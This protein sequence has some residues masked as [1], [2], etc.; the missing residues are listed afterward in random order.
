VDHVPVLLEEALHLLAVRP[1]GVYLDGTLGAG[2]HAAEI[3]RRS[4]PEGRVI[5]F[6]KDARA[7]E[8]ARE[9]LAP[10][11]GRVSFVHA[12]F[13]EAKAVL[14]EEKL[15]GVLL[16]LGVSSLQLDAPERGFSFRA[17]GPLDMRMDESRGPTAADLVNRLP[18]SALADLVYRYGEEPASRR[19]ARALVAAR[20]KKPFSTTGELAA[21][22][23]RA[24]W[25]SRR[26]GLDP[27]TRTFQALRIAVNDELAGLEEA[28]AALASA[29]KP[30][31]RLAVISFHSLEDRVV[32]RAFR[33]LAAGGGFALLT[34]KPVRPGQA[35]TRRNPRARSARLRGLLREAA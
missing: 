27:A 16:D 12:D 25:R 26:R 35:E 14:R 15:D 21:V 7:L 33:A 30:G 17:D 32:K 18:E 3:L 4:A 22:V 9:A 5:G 8:R 1:G 6:D 24:A 20:A 23:R 19:I 29:L 13:K 10:F 31:G 2:G 11:P 34:R 28:L